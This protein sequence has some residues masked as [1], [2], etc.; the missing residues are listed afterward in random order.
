MRTL[1]AFIA[2]NV[3]LTFKKLALQKLLIEIRRKNIF[4]R[5]FLVREQK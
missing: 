4:I 2:I 3:K 5:I 1:F